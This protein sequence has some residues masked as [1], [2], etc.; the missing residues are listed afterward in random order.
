[1]GEG[2][3]EVAELPADGVDLIREQAQ[4][5][6]LPLQSRSS[7]AVRFGRPDSRP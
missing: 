4:V 7:A 6:R 3:R 1:M 2:V 5:E